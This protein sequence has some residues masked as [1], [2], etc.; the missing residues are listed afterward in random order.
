[1]A[2]SKDP[3]TVDETVTLTATVARTSGTGALGTGTVVFLDGTVE[4]GRRPLGTDGTASISRSFTVG[5][6][7]I[8]ARFEDGDLLVGSTSTVFTQDITTGTSV[9]AVPTTTTLQRVGDTVVATVAVASGQPAAAGKVVFT[10]DGTPR[11]AIDL[12]SGKATLPLAGLS[13]GNHTVTAAYQG[14]D[15]HG[16]STSAPL[17]VTIVAATP[18]GAP[19]TPTVTAAGATTATVTFTAP[20]ATGSTPITGYKVTVT[21]ATGGVVKTVDVAGSPG[22]VTGLVGGTV[23]RFRVQAVNQ[24]GAGAA[25]ALSA[26]A[27]PPFKTVDAFTTQQFR[28]LA[29]RVPTGTELTS[30]RTQLTGGTKTPAALVETLATGTSAAQYGTIAR[31]YSAYFLRLPGP[32]E[33]DYWVGELRKGVNVYKISEGFAKSNEFKTRY[34]NLTNADFVRLVYTNVLGRTPSTSEAAYWTGELNK[35]VTR[36][37]VMV[38]FSESAE[39]KAKLAGQTNLVTLTRLM[40]GRAPTAAERTAWEPKPR[41]EVIAWILSSAAYDTRIP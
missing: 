26:H 37:K 36:G 28:D 16:V 31:L 10:V 32:S 25:S 18:P 29:G 4:I 12:A 14:S 41:L 21:N 30:W 39:N 24:A 5:Q 19:G 7:P 15:T 35:G 34:G 17:T 11:P 27:I 38:G 40:L 1:V 8:T 13:V 9:P 22:T 2:S 3:A 6:H 20:T 23:Y 33:L